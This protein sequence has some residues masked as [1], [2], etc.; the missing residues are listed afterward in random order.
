MS[1]TKR[2]R[3]S[4]PRTTR[5]SFRIRQHP[6]SLTREAQVQAVVT[7][8]FF[9]SGKEVSAPK[10]TDETLEVHQFITEPA[11]VTVEMGM[12]VNLGNYEAARISV[13]LSVPCYREEHEEAYEYARSWVEKKTLAEAGE[14]KRFA[15]QRTGF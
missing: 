11:K 7:R 6:T 4:S 9:K 10:Q 15:Q 3:A 1:T 2:F 13:T 12:T 14:A 5:E 8:Q